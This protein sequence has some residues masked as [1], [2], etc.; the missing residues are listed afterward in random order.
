MK[1]P[2]F[3]SILVT[4]LLLLLGSLEG[5][6]QTPGSSVEIVVV[7]T[8]DHHGST[9]S[10]DS[11]GGLAVRSSMINNLRKK[12]KNV[13]LLDAGDINTGMAISNMFQAVPD[14]LAYN[15]MK[16]DAV[17]IG[18]HEFD[19]PESV[20]THQREMAQFPF[21][22]ANIRRQ[23]T[24]DFLVKPYIIKSFQGV[25]V[26]IFGITISQ[27]N[28][29]PKTGQYIIADDE[30]EAARKMVDQLRN[31]EKV[32]VV[33]AV[34]HLGDKQLFDSHIT[35]IELGKKVAGIDLIIDGHAHSYI[36]KPIM[37]SATPIV[38]A[39]AYGQYLGEA[40]LSVCTDSSGKK[41]VRL[42]SWSINP[43]TDAV[44]PDPVFVELLKPYVDKAK[45]SLNQVVGHT[46]AEFILNEKQSR[47]EEHPWCDWVCD[48]ISEFLQQRNM[49]VDFT[50]N[51]GGVFRAGLPKGEITHGDI[52]TSLPFNNTVVICSMTG[53]QVK[54]LFEFVASIRQTAGGFAQ[55]SRS[56]RYTISYDLQGNGTLSNLLING[57]PVDENKIYRI[58]TNSYM[59][60]GG[61]G[62]TIFE[63][64][65]DFLDT[66]VLVNEAI[67][68]VL[69]RQ[70]EPLSPV[71]DGR[72]T[73]IG[74]MKTKK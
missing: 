59:Y 1:K 45:A 40:I 18:N 74:G 54:S 72:I 11:C 60:S 14:I 7:H 50:I 63:K 13:L 15:A 8:N 25:R 33:I 28:L 56:V 43:I 17:A 26:G 3:Y 29:L 34:T 61:D 10:I 65:T 55:V 35:S 6:G 39:K 48:A 51:N 44:T 23:D 68:D 20:F 73:I 67:V 24:R 16:Y 46:T 71:T 22:C 53:R 52:E 69:S 38:T 62:Y 70:K 36:T 12:Y 32:D 64:S 9:I 5:C 41:T 31:K 47:I 66:A 21:I 27:L 30:I 19:I 37:A 4:V 57:K 58:A 2:C 49:P 42:K